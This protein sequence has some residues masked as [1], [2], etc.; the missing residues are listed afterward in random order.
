MLRLLGKA[1]SSEEMTLPALKPFSGPFSGSEE[2]LK[3]TKTGSM[4]KFLKLSKSSSSDHMKQPKASSEE[5]SLVQ[6]THFLNIFLRFL[7][8]NNLLNNTSLYREPN[9]SS[10]ECCRS[11]NSSS[12]SSSKYKRRRRLSSRRRTWPTPT[13]RTT[14][15]GGFTPCPPPPSCPG[16]SLSATRNRPSRRSLSVPT[17]TTSPSIRRRRQ[18]QRPRRRIRPPRQPRQRRIRRQRLPRR[19]RTR[20]RRRQQRRRRRIR[21][22]P[23]GISRSKKIFVDTRSSNGLRGRKKVK[24]N[25]EK[26]RN[27]EKNDCREIFDERSTTLDY[28]K[29]IMMKM[30]ITIINIHT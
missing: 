22:M 7:T 17:P 14:S 13:R 18:R 27:P 29:M 20:Q 30:T 15:T 8:M 5:L 1:K 12:N 16:T 9:R 26:R 25:G 28:G 3:L 4:E 19:Q 21:P 6:A 10:K 24:K 2:Q 11:N 23:R